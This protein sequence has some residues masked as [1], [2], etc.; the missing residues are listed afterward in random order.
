[1]VKSP[2]SSTPP[3]SLYTNNLAPQ[4]NNPDVLVMKP[5]TNNHKIS[6]ERIAPKQ[7]VTVSSNH[8]NTSSSSPANLSTTNSIVELVYN[9]KSPPSVPATTSYLKV[10]WF[11][12]LVYYLVVIH[13]G[14]ILYILNKRDIIK[15]N[16]FVEKQN[17]QKNKNKTTNNLK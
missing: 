13:L 2:P 4:K 8:T 11:M 10:D 9:K 17:K 1:M 12:L 5:T 15:V 3:S 6:I 7:P 16:P 14:I